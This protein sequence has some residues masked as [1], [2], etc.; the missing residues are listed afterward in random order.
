MVKSNRESGL[1]RYD[2]V[3]E[4]KD[5]ENVAVIME[6]KVFDSEDEA[7]LADTAASALKQI[8]EKKYDTDLLQRGIPAEKILKYGFA[9]EG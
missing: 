8:E 3:M 1:G 4:P 7:E 6:F 5:M 9:F 2:V